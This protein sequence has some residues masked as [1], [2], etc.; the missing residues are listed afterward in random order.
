MSAPLGEGLGFAMTP[1]G[2]VIAFGVGAV[3]AFV[4]GGPIMQM[5]LSPL[6]AQL[7]PEG[8]QLIFQGPQEAF[9]IY[10]KQALLAG[11]ILAVPCLLFQS[12]RIFA[13]TLFQHV[14]RSVA[15]YACVGGIIAIVAAAFVL[16]Y[17]AP[18]AVSAAFAYM[19]QSAPDLPMLGFASEYLRAA[20]KMA[21][22]Y[23]AL[24]QVPLIF[25]MMVKSMRTKRVLQSEAQP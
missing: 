14:P 15:I 6:C 7:G 10:F 17:E 21:G 19:S 12:A 24:L 22:S 20:L 13:P 1:L 25:A 8:C 18:R 11:F 16:F 9:F 5:I 23:V 2:G 3:I 4:L